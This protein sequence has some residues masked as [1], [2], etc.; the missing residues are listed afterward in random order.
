[1]A[2]GGL[3]QR[4]FPRFSAECKIMI[5]GKEGHPIQ[6][7]TENLGAGGVCVILKQ[8]LEKLSLV[9]LRLNLDERTPPIE[10]DGRVIWMVP[11]KGFGGFGAKRATFDT[12]IEFLNLP[13]ET[14]AAITAFVQ[15]I[16]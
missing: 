14:G 12:G 4:A 3:D 15:K 8:E 11:S 16:D 10:C 7:K 1:M 5:Q 6:A 9:R 13:P 2:W